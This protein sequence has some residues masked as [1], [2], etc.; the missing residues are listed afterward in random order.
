MFLSSSRW[1]KSRSK[2]A[3]DCECLAF[4]HDQS[5]GKCERDLFNGGRIT[6]ILKFNG[7]FMF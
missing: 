4:V 5:K 3:H 1:S 6:L 2:I 7:H